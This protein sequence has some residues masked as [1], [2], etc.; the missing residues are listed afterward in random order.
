M[1][2]QRSAQTG[3]SLKRR[4]YSA[5]A[6]A[7]G[8]ADS[9]TQGLDVVWPGSDS[10]LPKSRVRRCHNGVSSSSSCTRLRQG[11]VWP[12]AGPWEPSDLDLALYP[13]GAVQNAGRRH[14]QIVEK[15]TSSSLFFAT[16]T[17]PGRPNT[18]TSQVGSSRF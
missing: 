17:P 5:T 3:A 12:G 2:K 9:V 10:W 13:A 11:A 7:D 16:S 6:F 14:H 15:Q 4:N 8:K 1:I 18:K